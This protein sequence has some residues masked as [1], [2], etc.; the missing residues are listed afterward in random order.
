VDLEYEAER[1]RQKLCV[2]NRDGT[3]N[4]RTDHGPRER[5]RGVEAFMDHSVVGFADWTELG[6][7]PP[8]LPG[9][10]G[11]RLRNSKEGAGGSWSASPRDRSWHGFSD[12]YLSYAPKSSQTSI[13]C[14]SPSSGWIRLPS[15]S[16]T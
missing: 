15:A 10:L 13:N 1:A 9:Q 6:T 5:V 7:T 8:R 12:A 14:P 16:K 3:R 4:R 11:K 2:V